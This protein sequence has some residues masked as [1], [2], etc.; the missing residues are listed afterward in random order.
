MAISQHAFMI[1]AKQSVAVVAFRFRLLRALKLC[2]SLQRSSFSAPL[3]G[4]FLGKQPQHYLSSFPLSLIRID[5]VKA[6]MYV[7]K[8]SRPSFN[9]YK[10]TSQG[11][12]LYIKNVT[13]FLLHLSSI[14]SIPVRSSQL[15]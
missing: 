10:N 12:R 15:A 9:F 6:V 13:L 3:L 4:L 5:S 7:I 14:A 8:R 1:L 11:P 2:S